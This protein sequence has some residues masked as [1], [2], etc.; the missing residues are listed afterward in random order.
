MTKERPFLSKSIPKIN[1]SKDTRSSS[2]KQDIVSLD[3][4]ILL[5]NRYIK[6]GKLSSAL[7]VLNSVENKDQNYDKFWQVHALYHHNSLDIDT[8]IESYKKFVIVDDLLATG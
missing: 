1:L 5:I 6:E 3:D 7:N 2:V 8:A 4:K